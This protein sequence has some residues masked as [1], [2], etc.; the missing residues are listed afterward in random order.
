MHL[1]ILGDI[2]SQYPESDYDLAK[3]HIKSTFRTFFLDCLGMH[4]RLDKI[5]APIGYA[6]AMGWAKGVVDPEYPRDPLVMRSNSTAVPEG[7]SYQG[8]PAFDPRDQANIRFYI[9][10]HDEDMSNHLLD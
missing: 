4:G 8:I 2:C 9:K 1:N 10:H 6:Y 3:E 5:G 7:S